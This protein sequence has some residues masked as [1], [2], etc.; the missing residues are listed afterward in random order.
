MLRFVLFSLVSFIV[1]MSC[2]GQTFQYSRGWTN[3]KRS[4]SH[5]HEDPAIA[6]V[7]EIP[8]ESERRLEKCIIQLQ[9][10]IHNPYLVRPSYGPTSNVNGGSGVNVHHQSNENFEDMAASETGEFSTKHN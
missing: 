8:S 7:F 6:E 2:M 9:R 3:G 5:L 4:S 1:I 10:L